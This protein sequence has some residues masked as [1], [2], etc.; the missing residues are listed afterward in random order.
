MTLS[1]LHYMVAVAEN[2]NFT[3]AAK[4]LNVTQPT[5]SMQVQKLEEELDVKIF[6]RK[7]KPV[8]LTEVG[9][10]IV[11]QAKKIILEANKIKDT[12]DIEKG[13]IKGD[14]RLG[15]LPGLMNSLVPIFLNE[16]IT[17]YK[18]INLILEE[19]TSYKLIKSLELGKLDAAITSTPLKNDKL[20]ERPLFYEPFVLYL[21]PDHRLN[22][23]EFIGKE[24]IEN[25]QILIPK[26]G[27]CFRNQILNYFSK[28]N[29][30]NNKKL[31]LNSNSFK[32][33]I[34]LTDKGFGITILPYLTARKL[35]NEKNNFIKNFKTPPPAREIS[36]VY[37][38]S[39]LRIQIIQV[40]KET[41][42]TKI[43][44]K[45]PLNDTQIV[46]PTIL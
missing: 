26:K 28:I 10:K 5:L 7:K 15:I 13:F 44:G 24:D 21:P 6:N 12:I 46:S 29:D 2:K 33:L 23:I 19:L 9:E 3:M 32:T 36:L 30:G 17:K 42:N 1:Q 40:L 45:L 31:S 41:I 18:S 27:N 38:K 43:R 16:F 22:S 35:I 20:I 11:L 8:I 4:K 34:D 39:E 25:E 37:P 14:F